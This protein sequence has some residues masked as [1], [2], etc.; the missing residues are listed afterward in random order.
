MYTDS[1]K[2]NDGVYN[3]TWGE[4]DKAGLAAVGATNECF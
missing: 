1:F 4:G 3:L 2:E